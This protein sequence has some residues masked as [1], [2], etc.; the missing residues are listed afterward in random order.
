M[1]VHKRARA[2]TVW[3]QVLGL[4]QTEYENRL[5]VRPH[6]LIDISSV[7]SSHICPW[8]PTGYSFRVVLHADA[9]STLYFMFENHFPQFILLDM[10]FARGGIH[11]LHDNHISAITALGEESASRGICLER[12]DDLYLGYNT[13]VTRLSC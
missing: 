13:H 9:P 6:L 10:F 5:Q 8:I 7:Q 4:W 3:Q 2:R 12:R 11:S 1:K